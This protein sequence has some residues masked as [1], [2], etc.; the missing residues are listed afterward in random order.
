MCELSLIVVARDVAYSNVKRAPNFHAATTFKT[1]CRGKGFQ[2]HSRQ[3]PKCKQS[4]PKKVVTRKFAEVMFAWKMRWRDHEISMSSPNAFVATTFATRA[5]IE[6]AQ[7]N[8]ATW[9][10]ASC[11]QG[12]AQVTIWRSTPGN[13]WASKQECIQINICH[14]K[15]CNL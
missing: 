2:D 1:N 15:R 5:T 4:V 6:S 14:L 13:V 12:S 3:R 8:A 11:R 10:V 7:K 9:N